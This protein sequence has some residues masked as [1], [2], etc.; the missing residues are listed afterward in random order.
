MQRLQ[1][2]GRYLVLFDLDGTLY[3]L[4]GGSYRRSPLRT[5]VR[6]NARR[7]LERRLRVSIAR[8]Q[9]ILCDIE[10]EYGE[11]ISIGVE[12]R[13]RISRQAYFRSVWDIPAQR[14]ILPP[15]GLRRTVQRIRR[16][17]DVAVISDAPRIWVDRVLHV[18]GI[19]S[20]FRGRTLSGEGNVRKG[21]GNA[22]RSLIARYHLDP[23]RCIV[24]GDQEAT[25]IIPARA[26][27]MWTIL[28][29]QRRGRTQADASVQNFVAL[30]S[31]LVRLTGA[32]ERGTTGARRT[33]T[34]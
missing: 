5:A 9:Q 32:G 30:E 13:F 11:D 25:D 26:A 18:L 28:V 23:R 4:R 19:A 33:F 17:F 7:F 12:R 15:S 1:R 27:G 34:T 6:T 21:L 14:Y 20:F 24:V 29:R 31:T 10:R 16:Q 22:F 3:P 8:A 2:P